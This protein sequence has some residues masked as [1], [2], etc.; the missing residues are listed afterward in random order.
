M[1]FNMLMQSNLTLIGFGVI[2]V[3]SLNTL[4]E[5]IKK[6]KKIK[7]LIIE[8]DLRN[9]PG[10][11]AYSK[12]SSKFGFFNNPLRLSHS[13]FITWMYN[14]KNILKLINFIEN[15]PGHFLKDWLNKNNN[16]I[17]KKN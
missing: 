7:I 2:G 16:N 9:I 12:Q 15:N 14:K 3:E 17:K 8:K 10:G 11:I 13:S 1:I 5:K 4:V 6:E